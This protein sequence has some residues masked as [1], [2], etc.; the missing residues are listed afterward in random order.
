MAQLATGALAPCVD[1]ALVCSRQKATYEWRL[2]L[3][4][5]RNNA[6]S[7]ARTRDGRH[8]EATARHSREHDIAQLGDLSRREFVGRLAVT[9][10]TELPPAPRVQRSSIC[11]TWERP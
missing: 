9:E 8:V 3:P 5:T 4:S 6:A 7:R 11:A 10:L 2:E 1:V